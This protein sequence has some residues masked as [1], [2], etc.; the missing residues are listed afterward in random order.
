MSHSELLAFIKR[1]R[2]D[3]G[4]RKQLSSLNSPEKILA[5]VESSGFSFSSEVR[6]RFLNR[7]KGVYF[8]PQAIEVGELC[9]AL[10]PEGYRNLIHY[11]QS[12]CASP[13]LKEEEF[14]FRSGERY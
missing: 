11:S 3:S 13:E 5:F 8:C 10:V 1:G 4:F 12:T 9:P 14:N 2:V 6:G 7:W